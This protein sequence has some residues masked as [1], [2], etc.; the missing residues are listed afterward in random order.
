MADMTLEVRP[1]KR[2]LIDSWLEQGYMPGSLSE[3][4]RKADIEA[5]ILQDPVCPGCNL[6][7]D[8]MGRADRHWFIYQS[9]HKDGR[10][11]GL[12]SCRQCGYC[13]EV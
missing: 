10:Y 13:D 8:P 12:I 1:S 5:V 6:A 3:K 2:E 11:R 9:F 7:R 4:V